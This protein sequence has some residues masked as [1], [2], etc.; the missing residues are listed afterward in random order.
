[1]Q[2][3]ITLAGLAYATPDGRQLFNN[4]DLAFGRERT[5]IVGRN[6]A[7]K[8]TL[9]RLITGELAPSAGTVSVSGRLG[10]LR[11]AVQ[12]AAGSTLADALG[13]REALG[14]LARIEAGQG[15]EADLSLA[16]WTLETRLRTALAEVD[17]ADVD[18]DRPANT[19]SGGELTRASLAGLI[20]DEPDV[21]ILDE[22]TNNLDAG[23]R[24]TVAE[25]LG[26]WR[27]G[28]LVVSH[29]RALLRRMDRTLELSSLGARLYGGGYDLYAERKAEERAAAERDL[30][31]AQQ[32][33]AR[34]SREIQTARER[35]DRRDVAGRKFA[36]S[37][38][39]PRIALGGMKRRAEETS[40]RGERLA[41]RQ[42]EDAAGQ[43]IQAEARVER[44]R[45]LDFDL[46]SSALPAGRVVLDVQALS[47]G[48]DRP[49]LT[50]VDLKLTGPERVAIV[51]P[52][53][54]G[55]TTLLRL[56]DGQLKPSAGQVRVTER[57]VMLDQ[58]TA[59]LDGAATVIDAFRRLNPG[60]S[61]NA[62]HAALARFL[63]RNAAAL[64]PIAQLSGGERLR[65]ALAA[66]LSRDPTPELLILDEPTNHLDLDSVAAIEA[67]LRGY[68]G[69]LLVVSHDRDFLQAIGVEREAGL[70]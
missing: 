20:A 13:V 31:S 14:R 66:V 27:G 50:G 2:A 42:R 26:R 52:N 65:A 39:A 23:A 53:G 41:E 19:L 58:R 1:M 22:P 49:I 70:G 59:I 6:G 9:L 68:D 12:P 18:F 15:S 61:D 62:A 30:A 5:A 60:A 63:F 35:K 25:V 55:K 69:A 47:V 38:S 46:P 56:I 57:R 16:D 36:A 40:A 28:A 44:L 37:G 7:G 67:A 10:L 29:D 33:Q 24:Q 34:V 3:L 17:L 4:L 64:T 45:L 21:L 32:E 11:Q 51:G 54:A 8:T 48:Y 43:L